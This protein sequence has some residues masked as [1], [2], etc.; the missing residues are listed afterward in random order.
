[1]KHADC[2]LMLAPWYSPVW[3]GF[4]SFPLQTAGAWCGCVGAGAPGIAE[5]SQCLHGCRLAPQL[6]W[7]LQE[8]AAVSFYVISS[9][10][11]VRPVPLFGYYFLEDSLHITTP[12]F[13]YPNPI[14]QTMYSPICGDLPGA[15]SL[16]LQSSSGSSSHSDHSLPF[17][18]YLFPSQDFKKMFIDW[19]GCAG[20]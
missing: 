3:L 18:N 10:S 4:V 1:M 13:P 17:L 16:Y 5:M 7:L 11:F 9:L 19:F 2:R 14:I 12:W 6:V 15:L 20:S 8:E